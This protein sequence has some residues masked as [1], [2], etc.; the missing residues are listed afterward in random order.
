MKHLEAGRVVLYTKGTQLLRGGAV[1]RCVSYGEA[2][3]FQV[4]F[5]VVSEMER[6]LLLQKGMLLCIKDHD[7]QPEL[8]L[9]P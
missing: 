3:G 7:R 9:Y 4:Q 1:M 2:A 5:P 6:E 8:C